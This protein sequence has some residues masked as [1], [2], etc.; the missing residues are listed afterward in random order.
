MDFLRLRQFTLLNRKKTDPNKFIFTGTATDSPPD[1]QLFTY[2]KDNVNEEQN[3][4]FSDVQ[5]LRSA[6]NRNW[7]NVYGL[8]DPEVIASICQKQGIDNLVIQDILD[9]NQKPK[10]ELFDTYC[11]LTIKTTVPSST[12]MMVEQISFVFG[13]HFLISFQE[14]K[15]D[16]FDH[17]RYRL[18][19][20][21]G[22]IRER[23][24]D[25]LLYT[26]LESILDNYF[27]TLNSI[28]KEVSS[29]NLAN[30]KKEFSPTVLEEIEQYKTFTHFII[31]AI[32]PIKEFVVNIESER[33]QFIE[34][35]N[36]KF[37]YEI[38]DL[39]LTLIDNCNTLITSLESSTNLFFS[40]QG[41]KMNQIMK[42]LTIV[43]TVFIPLTFIA[44]IYGMNFAHMPELGWKYGYPAVWILIL[45]TL[46][47]MIIY[48][49][50]KR[51]L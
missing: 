49:R 46:L 37:F 10:Y 6:D 34:K 14:K 26:M 30:F 25:F 24:A 36:L 51:W 50:R 33:N 3:L 9:I 18:R 35:K 11:F 32:Q 19:E 40:I 29:L 2:T 7:L 22:V 21:K 20:D 16:Y 44:G 45:V 39:C 43:A 8:N 12:E 17:L 15:A 42:T 48:F 41:H 5:D 4:T 27:K 28:S 13:K 38:K 47:G 31:K 23:G 1:I